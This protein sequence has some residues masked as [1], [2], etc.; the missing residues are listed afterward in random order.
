MTSGIR[1]IIFFALIIAMAYISWA[2]MIKPANA[3]LAQERTMAEQKQA[4]LQELD[5]AKSTASDLHAQLERVEEAI[6]VFESKLPP[7]SEI[8]TVLENVT[9]IAQ[10]NGLT[11]KTISTLKPSNKNGYIE[12]PLKMELHGDFNSYYAFMLELERMD[13]ITKIR[14][15]TLKKK[16]QFEGQTEATFVMSIFFMDSK[17]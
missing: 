13:R 3:A 17:N 6:Q 1:H 7:K 14:E 4:K 12:Q 10:K 16:S 5:R 9:L 11:P 15:L 2:Y 8:H